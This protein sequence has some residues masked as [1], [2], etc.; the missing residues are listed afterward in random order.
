M[1]SSCLGF[2][3]PPV[4]DTPVHTIGNSLGYGTGL[5]ITLLSLPGWAQ[6]VAS[7]DQESVRALIQ[8]VKEL[9]QRD[10]ELEER[11]KVLEAGQKLAASPETVPVPAEAS[12][13]SVA[14]AA[15]L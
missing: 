14:Q 13:P 1:H 4:G 6:D 11:V 10:R 8:Q 7:G 12:I 2:P 9:Q 3:G 15:S 5:L